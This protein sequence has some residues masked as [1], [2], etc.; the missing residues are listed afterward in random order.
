MSTMLKNDARIEIIADDR[1][2]TGYVIESLLGIETPQSER[3]KK[4]TI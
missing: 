1:E 3:V 2:Q 4:A